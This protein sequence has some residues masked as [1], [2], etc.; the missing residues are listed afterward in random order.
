MKIT[1]TKEN[2]VNSDMFYHITAKDSKGSPVKCRR[3]GKTKTW[4]TRPLLFSIPVVCGLRDYF[5]IDNMNCHFW[6][7]EK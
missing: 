3:N 6:Q 7:V 2:Q 4:I 5:H 1:V